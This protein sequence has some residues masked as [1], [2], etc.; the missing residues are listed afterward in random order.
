MI[1]YMCSFYSCNVTV[2]IRWSIILTQTDGRPQTTQRRPIHHHLQLSQTRGQ[3][4]HGKVSKE[5]AQTGQKLYL[6]DHLHQKDD[7]QTL[8]G[9][10]EASQQQLVK[11]V[12]WS[13]TVSVGVPVLA[14]IKGRLLQWEVVVERYPFVG[15][16]GRRRPLQPERG[17]SYFQLQ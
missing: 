6:M 5:G 11:Q 14:W 4:T 10:G 17:E 2:N 9:E 8:A 7:C 12:G 1:N 3:G 13:G 15:V 16:R